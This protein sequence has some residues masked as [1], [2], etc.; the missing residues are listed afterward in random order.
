MRGASS[1]QRDSLTRKLK[2]LTTDTMRH[3]V[4]LEELMGKIQKAKVTNA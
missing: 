1:T 3:I 2:P 4:R